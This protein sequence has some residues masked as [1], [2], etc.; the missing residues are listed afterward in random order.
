MVARAS[1]AT[2]SG[3]AAFGHD[4]EEEL[5]RRKRAG[6]RGERGVCSRW[7]CRCAQVGSG[8]IDGDESTTKAK[9][10]VGEEEVAGLAVVAPFS[11]RL[12]QRE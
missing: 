2:R 10:A 4:G 9:T 5:Q 7:S 11:L 3:G 1:S 6:K 8:K 12:V